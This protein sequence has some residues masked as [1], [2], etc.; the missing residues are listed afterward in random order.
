MFLLV[1][2]IIS[3]KRLQF[4]LAAPEVEGCVVK[5]SWKRSGDEEAMNGEEVVRFVSLIFLTVF[6]REQERF[7]LS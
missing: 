6:D 2:G 7:R 1:N 5:S 4:F 3:T